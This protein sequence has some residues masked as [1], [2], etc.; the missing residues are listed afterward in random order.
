MRCFVLIVAIVTVGAWT[1]GCGG[2]RR[3]GMPGPRE[4]GGVPAIGCTPGGPARTCDGVI[5][6]TC[7]PDGSVASMRSCADTS[8]VCSSGVGCTTCAASRPSCDGNTS[9]I[10]RADGSGFDPVMDCSAMGLSCDASSGVC[11]DLCASAATSSSYIGC[12]YWPTTVMN[13]VD[14]EFEFAVAVA[15]PQSIPAQITVT[16]AG[17]SVATATVAPNAL[18]TIRLPWVDAVKFP[19]RARADDPESAQT[20]SALAR[21]GAYRLT[22]SVPVTVY[23]FNPLEYEIA[24]DCVA[25]ADVPPDGRCNSFTNDASLLLPSHVLTGNYIVMSFP[26]QHTRLRVRDDLTGEIVTDPLTGEVFEQHTFTPG[27]VAVIAAEST[28]VEVTTSAHVEASIDGAVTAMRAGQ[29]ASFT[30]EAGDVLELATQ[31]APAACTTRVADDEQPTDC[32]GVP[33]TAIFSYCSV[34]ADYDLTGTEIRATGRVSVIAGHQCAFVP[35]NRWACDHLEE[36][37]FPLDA[38]GRDFIVST[39]EPLRGEP[40]VVRVL[41]GTDGNAITFEPASVHEPV[42]LDRGQF[43]EF[44]TRESVRAVGTGPISVAQFL[45]GQDYDGFG[46]SGMMGQGDPSLSLAIPTEQFR[47]NY[48]FLAPSTYER[49]FV[50]VT[51]PTGVQVLLDGVPVTG[52][53]P[54]GS[55]GYSVARVSV[56]GGQHA[57]RS[58]SP[59]GIVV[60]GFGAYTSYMVPGGLDLEAINPLI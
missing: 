36:A 2:G 39:T 11:A 54:I 21:D 55:T 8:Q 34:G 60:Y 16:R 9:V 24:H 32:G 59:F 49:N 33:C 25:E 28:S 53:A 18:E 35:Y 31:D 30:L 17:A 22:S 19:F 3:D 47:D 14:S 56:A 20:L 48:V 42:T 40:N 46:A 7:N 41:S 5:E 12:E 52:F 13:G 45:V 10:C 26:A 1:V 57:I 44:E 51:A 43:V 58:A 50:N 6:L 27:F 23:Q 15:N 37:L 38:W 4:D 29:T